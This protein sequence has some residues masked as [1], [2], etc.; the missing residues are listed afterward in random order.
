MSGFDREKV[1]EAFLGGY[2]WKSN[3]LINLG[4]GDPAALFPRNPR[5]R[6][7]RGVL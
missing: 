6:F 3:F 5:L 4:H 2:G 7:R 1:D